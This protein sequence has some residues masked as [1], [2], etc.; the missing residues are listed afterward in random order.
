M[1][2]CVQATMPCQCSAKFLPRLTTRLMDQAH[3]RLASSA[4]PCSCVAGDTG[5]S[6][7]E[8]DSRARETIALPPQPQVGE[9]AAAFRALAQASASNTH[10][11]AAA[12]SALAATCCHACGRSCNRCAC[13]WSL[14]PHGAHLTPACFDPCLRRAQDELGRM[15]LVEALAS[16]L[17][18][19]SGDSS[20]SGSDAILR[21]LLHS[22]RNLCAGHAPNAWRL[23][24][25]G[26]WGSVKAGKAAAVLGNRDRAWPWG[27]ELRAAGVAAAVSLLGQPSTQ[28]FLATQTNLHFLTH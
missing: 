21:D 27:H 6:L 15:G 24:E 28:P 14:C 1:P 5:V 26:G 18:L 2:A 25:A 12:R 11:P 3:E 23:H 10:D 19:A 22:L 13:Q 9:G 8:T 20:G 4:A 16:S 17:A 7:A